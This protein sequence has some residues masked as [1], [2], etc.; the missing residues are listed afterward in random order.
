[1]VE[2]LS[3]GGDQQTL[4]LRYLVQ[5]SSIS[6]DVIFTIMMPGTIWW[7]FHQILGRRV[8]VDYSKVLFPR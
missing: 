3:V 6:K 4:G 1:M 5:P 2:E 8:K 7:I